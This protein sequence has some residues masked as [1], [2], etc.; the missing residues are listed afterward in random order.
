MLSHIGCYGLQGFAKAHC[1]EPLGQTC[2]QTRHPIAL[3]AL[4][5]AEETPLAFLSPRSRKRSSRDLPPI[6]SFAR[7]ARS[8]RQ[9]GMRCCGFWD[10]QVKV[11]E[12]IALPRRLLWL[13]SVRDLRRS[14]KHH[15]KGVVQ[16]VREVGRYFA[17]WRVGQKSQRCDLRLCN[18][19]QPATCRIALKLPTSRSFCFQ[20]RV[21]NLVSRCHMPASGQGHAFCLAVTCLFARMLRLAKFTNLC[22][23]A[24]AKS[25]VRRETQPGFMSRRPRVAVQGPPWIHSQLQS[26]MG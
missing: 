8:R 21:I 1:R 19:K 12:S 17:F 4:A 20:A 25:P 22:S 7:V 24:V 11:G 14:K 6:R 13:A 9:S 10:S 3:R 18:A 23:V 26:G 15:S 5:A 16:K 2:A